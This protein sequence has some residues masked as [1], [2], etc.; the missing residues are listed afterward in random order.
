MFC[1]FCG[2]L[3]QDDSVYCPCCGK[4]L[5]APT[6]QKQIKYNIKNEKI[7]IFASVV[8]Y[9]GL[10]VFLL[11]YIKMAPGYGDIRL[12]TYIIGVAIAI[13]ISVFLGKI[14]YK[15]KSNR[16]DIVAIA[17]GFVMLFS[18]VGVFVSLLNVC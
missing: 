9:I 3:I 13:V 14:R 12:L 6:E 4:E 18:S 17:I 10:A 8:F 1:R 11:L 5:S 16:W 2:K 15:N 7:T